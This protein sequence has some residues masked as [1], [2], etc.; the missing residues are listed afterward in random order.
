MDV[1]STLNQHLA[2][3]DLLRAVQWIAQ[4]FWFLPSDPSSAK[5]TPCSTVLQKLAELHAGSMIPSKRG[6]QTQAREESSLL[7]LEISDTGL[8]GASQSF[9]T[10]QVCMR[11]IIEALAERLGGLPEAAD[12]QHIVIE[13]EDAD[14][15]TQLHPRLLQLCCPLLDQARIAL[16][17]HIMKHMLS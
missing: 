5:L 9:S 8:T 15:K 16:K 17:V 12:Q 6:S 13:W 14:S 1:E 4:F 10:L 7:Q 11:S 3:V 2:T